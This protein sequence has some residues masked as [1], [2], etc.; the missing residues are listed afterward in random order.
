M[1]ITKVTTKTGDG[2]ETGLATGAR[3]SKDDVRI[4]VIGDIDE[5]NCYIGLALEYLS[6]YM[7]ANVWF[8][9][10]KL[11]YVQHRLF[12]L[13]GELSA[14]KSII[15]ESDV[16]DVEKCIEILNKDL[17]PLENFILPG[18]TKASAYVHLARAVCRRAE[19]RLVTLMKEQESSDWPSLV[20]PQSVRYLNRLSD[21]L[22][23]VARTV[24]PNR[25]QVLWEPKPKV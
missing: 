6:T 16:E 15:N 9:K 10:G 21:L 1:R 20:N 23:V 25:Y 18:G 5:L 13:G 7:F 24:T 3:I 11:Q 17:P 4:E 19:R 14:C 22:F 12:D 2:G 8:Q